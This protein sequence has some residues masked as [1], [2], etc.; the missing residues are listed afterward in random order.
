MTVKPKIYRI[1]GAAP[2]TPAVITS[3]SLGA[4]DSNASLVLHPVKRGATGGSYI[5]TI[6]IGFDS[7]PGTA[8]A[9]YL[10]ATLID[11]ETGLPASLDENVVVKIATSL[12]T[13][14]VRATGTEDDHGDSI[15]T[16]YSL[17]SEDLLTYTS[18]SPKI[19]SGTD[20]VKTTGTGLFTKYIPLQIEIA[21][22]AALGAHPADPVELKLYCSALES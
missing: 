19:I 9:F 15:S 22:A 3:L 10:W 20:V 6:A 12:A 16:V 18:G 11:S 13:T 7:D 4:V 17:S 1:T 14:Y 8:T 21:E 2:G 5:A